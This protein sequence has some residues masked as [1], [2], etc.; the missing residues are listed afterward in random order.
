MQ[1]GVSTQDVGAI[2]RPLAWL[3]IRRVVAIVAFAGLVALGSHIRVPIPGSPVPLTFQV[4]FVLLAGALL[5]PGAAVSS[6]ALFVLAGI[7]GAPVFAAGG[8]GLLYL[9]GPTGGY[10]VGFIAGAA[11]CALILGGR[12]D[13]LARLV[14]SMTV[15]LAAIHLLGFAQL[16][17]SV[18]SRALPKEC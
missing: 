16:S 7:A 2:P 12:K 8:S 1:N 13:S 6:M 18:S 14:L 3:N 9:T 4:I 17:N 11:A 10:L 15:A 5:T